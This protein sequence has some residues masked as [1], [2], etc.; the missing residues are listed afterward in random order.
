MRLDVG[1]AV[2]KILYDDKRLMDIQISEEILELFEALRI[3]TVFG[4][5]PRLVPGAKLHL[6]CASPI[7][8]YVGLYTANHIPTIGAFS[9]SF[10]SFDREVSIGAYCSISWNVK[11][12]GINHPMETFS[13]TAA[14]YERHPMFNAAFDD[15]G[16]TRSYRR[17]PQK[18]LP[19]IGNDVWIGQ[20]VLLKRGITIGDG[21][22]IAG[23]SLVVKD[24][25]SYA[26][27]GG[28]P[29]KVIRYRF[30]ETE[31]EALQASRWWEF[32]MPDL[33]SRPADDIP[34]FIAS[35]QEGTADRAL[36]KIRQFDVS[37]ADL[38]RAG[39]VTQFTATL[40]SLTY[41][42]SKVV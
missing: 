23:G 27:V 40:P 8:P 41:V 16:I 12:M 33:I 11:V 7:Q 20:D 22:V 21:A 42:A 3:C 18:P 38:C 30:T 14:L 26:I 37:L 29:A 15:L 4:G 34:A 35:L 9:Y 32:A 10:S 25:P 13:T 5:P 36:R 31:R 28:S 19:V 6:N 24:V 17:N 2:T 1:E 39:S